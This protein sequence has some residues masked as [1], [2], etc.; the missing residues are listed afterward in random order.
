MTPHDAHAQREAV[1]LL[2]VRED[3]EWAAARVDGALH[4][5]MTQLPAR[6]AELDRTR[7]VAVLCRSGN[8]SAYV[9][10][11]LARVGLD[12]HNVDGGLQAWTAAGLP[13]SS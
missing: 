11:Y 9:V 4:I 10:E 12:A 1:Q 7:P 3:E 5:P 2:D 6:L 8:R 13:Y